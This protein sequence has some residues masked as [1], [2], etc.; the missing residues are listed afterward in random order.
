MKKIIIVSFVLAVVALFYI[1]SRT[2]FL[3]KIGGPWSVGYGF[4]N[5]IPNKLSINKKNIYNPEKLN[6]FS[7][8]TDFLAD[9]FFLHTKDTFYLFFE[10]KYKNDHDAA[11]AVLTSVDGINYEFK[12]DV[13]KEKFHLSYPQVFKHK[14]EYYMVPESKEAHN[15][16][17]Y[18]AKKFP[19]QWEISDTLVKNVSLKDP[20]LYLSDTLNLLVASDSKLSMYV[21]ESD[22]LTGEWKRRKK[23]I[24]QGSEARAG[25]RIFSNNNKLYLPV[26]NCSHGYGSSLSIYEFEFDK[27]KIGLKKTQADFLKAQADIPEF[28][29]GMHT[30]DIQK[31]GDKYYYVYDGNRIGNDQRKQA[32]MYALKLTFYDLK[33]YLEL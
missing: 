31:V 32:I 21:Y 9:S 15:I 2:P 24:L 6:T 16:L 8:G 19:Y 29:F 27:D 30:F 5:E 3:L 12:G 13:L 14:G 10:H 1:N 7:P 33:S 18:K 20:T 23:P 4:S 26:Q 17:L 22:S 25:G 28:G 11:I